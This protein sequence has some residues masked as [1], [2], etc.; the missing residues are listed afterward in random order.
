MFVVHKA[1]TA[2]PPVVSSTRFNEGCVWL[3][4]PVANS[5]VQL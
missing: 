4:V 1:D 2:E 3:A 5:L